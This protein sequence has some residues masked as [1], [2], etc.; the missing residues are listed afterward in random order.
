[1]ANVTPRIRLIR[2]GSAVDQTVLESACKFLREEWPVS[3]SYGRETFSECSLPERVEHLLSY[4]RSTEYDWLWAIRGGEGTADLLP[5]LGEQLR[6]GEDLPTKQLIGSSDATP[7]LIYLSE[8]SRI[9]PVHG[10]NIGQFYKIRSSASAKVIKSL[11]FN[12]TTSVTLKPLKP[13]NQLAK[14]NATLTAK[15]SIGGNL[16]LLSISIGDVWE[17]DATSKLLFLEDW[18]EKPHVIDRN[19]KSLERRGKFAGAI[20][21]L[22]GDVFRNLVAPSSASAEDHVDYLRRKLVE[23]AESLEIPVLE[24]GLVGHGDENFPIPLAWSV[25]LRLGAT[26]EISLSY[27]KT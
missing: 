4:C 6:Q 1:M 19:L 11:I 15:G 14:S 24:T 17:F 5:L 23:F 22:L 7:L 16:S 13:L 9:R 25:E 12:E 27:I 8:S 26:P 20:A 10:P 18:Q 21:I 2:L 3:V